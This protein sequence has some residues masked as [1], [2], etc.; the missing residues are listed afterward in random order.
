M[1]AEQVKQC[2]LDHIQNAEVEITGDDYHYQATI[3]SPVFQGKSLVQRQQLVYQALGQ[4]F[5]QGTLHAF[6]MKTFTPD[7]WAE[8]HG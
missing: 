1:R 4:A 6:S 2:I 3:I 5:T 8:Q 7:E